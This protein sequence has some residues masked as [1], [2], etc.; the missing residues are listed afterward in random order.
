MLM[1][2]ALQALVGLALFIAIG[3]VTRYCFRQW[4]ETTIKES[5]AASEKEMSKWKPVTGSFGEVKFDQSILATPQ[6]EFSQ[7]Q[8]NPGKT[9]GHR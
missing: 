4:L 1:P 3:F 8:T 6:F 2:R 7:P 9:S 5:Q